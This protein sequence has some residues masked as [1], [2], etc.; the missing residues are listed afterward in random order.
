M[1]KLI[2]G[3]L[4]LALLT[5]VLAGCGA[6]ANTPLPKSMKGYELYSWQ[7]AGQWR[8][9]LIT[10]TNRNKTLG[11]VI[12]GE[13]KEG[14]DGWVN[15]HV[16][17]VEEAKALLSRVPAGEWVSWS[18]YGTVGPEEGE[19]SSVNLELPPQDIINEIKEHALKCGIDSAVFG[20]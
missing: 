13:T 11:E 12:T 3:L 17:G 9:T 8:F 1:K 19:K 4:A 16:A 15:I 7:D 20:Q 18:R 6:T 2:L 5:P 14:E 10:G